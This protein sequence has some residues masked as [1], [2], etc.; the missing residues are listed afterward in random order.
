M[1][2]DRLEHGITI[3]RRLEAS[4]VG[5]ALNPEATNLLEMQCRWRE[6]H[7]QFDDGMMACLGWH[8]VLDR[9]FQAQ[10]LVPLEH[11]GDAFIPSYDGA[12]EFEALE[13]FFEITP[14]Q[15][16][17]MLGGDCTSLFDHAVVRIQNVIDQL[18]ARLLREIQHGQTRQ[19]KLL[20]EQ[21]I[22]SESV[23]EASCSS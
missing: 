19:L 14:Q 1:R 7:P 16:G 2:N 12:T 9:E 5:D 8:F 13:A 4:G 6:P 10:G 17:H 11:D 22:G 18:P 20:V 3:T 15:A 23:K 21:T